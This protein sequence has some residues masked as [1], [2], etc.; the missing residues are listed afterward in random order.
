MKLFFINLM[1]FF[2]GQVERIHSG[3]MAQKIKASAAIGV[4][5]SPVALIVKTYTDWFIS[6]SFFMSIVGLA[7]FFDLIFGI[8]AHSEKFLD[9]FDVWVMFGKFMLKFLV[10]YSSIFIFGLFVMLFELHGMDIG[11]YTRL[12]VSA[13]ILLFPTLSA[14][15]NMSIVTGGRYPPKDWILYLENK[16]KKIRL[17]E[18]LKRKK[19]E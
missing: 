11:I 3:S 17:S 9:D 2:C 16:Q 14:A 4:T 6:E 5:A 12:A 19:D 10:V 1:I 18:I 15:G 8:I 13:S 7:L